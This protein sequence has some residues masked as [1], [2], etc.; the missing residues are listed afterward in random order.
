L[1]AEFAKDPAHDPGADDKAG[2]RGASRGTSSVNGADL[3]DRE[4]VHGDL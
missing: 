2:E 4:S 3:R 1:P